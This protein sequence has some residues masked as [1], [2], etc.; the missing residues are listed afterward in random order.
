ML[1]T[2]AELW[3]SWLAGGIIDIDMYDYA[4]EQWHRSAVSYITAKYFSQFLFTERPKVH[5]NVLIASIIFST[6]WNIN[7]LSFGLVTN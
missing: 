4:T 7:A 3:T 1:D 6:I 5:R 2:G